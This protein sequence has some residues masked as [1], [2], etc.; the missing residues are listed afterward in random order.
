MNKL[1]ILV[2]FVLIGLTGLVI[3]SS[4]YHTLMVREGWNLIYGFTPGSLEGQALDFS[5]IKAIYTYIPQEK[6]YVQ[7]YPTPENSLIDKYGDSYFEKQVMWVYSDTSLR[8]EY[9]YEEALPYSGSELYAGWNF[10]GIRPDMQGKSLSELKGDCTLLKV[11]HFETI[12]QEW[13]PNLVH[14]DFM[15]EKLTSDSVGL[16]LAVNV[17]QNCKLGSSVT[18]PPTI[19]N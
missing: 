4:A 18:Q 13:S 19:P 15:D 3:A 12:I 16:G 7:I 9:R 1:F 11:Y 14:D 10:L 8:T 2:S 17:A 6:K 5:H